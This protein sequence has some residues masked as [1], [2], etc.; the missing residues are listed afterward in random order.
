M[1][2]TEAMFLAAL[3]AWLWGAPASAQP[4]GEAPTDPGLRELHTLVNAHRREVGCRPL[5]WHE[6]SATVAR[7]HSSDMA[8]RRYLD[9][10]DPE[11][12][13]FLERL[14]AGGVTWSGPV[15]ENLALTPAGAASVMELWLDSPGH[16]R[17][18]E[19]CAFTHHGVGSLDGLWT[20]LLL[21]NPG[22]RRE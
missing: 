15:S 12:T 20:Q 4:A 5:E 18:L 8:E 21:A 2:R 22:P 17:N 16:R 13:S 14:L 9:H 7:R 11:G 10:Q 3:A 6:A 19:N 1:P